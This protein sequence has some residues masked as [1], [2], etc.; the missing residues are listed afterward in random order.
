MIAGFERPT[1]GK[2]L[3]DGSDIGQVPPELRPF[4]MVFQ[5]YALF[6]H[7]SVFDNVAYGLRTARVAESDVRRRVMMRSSW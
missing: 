3:L 2:L 7:M 5:T 1:A 4:N 6:P